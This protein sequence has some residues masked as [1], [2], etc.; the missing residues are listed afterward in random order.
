MIPIEFMCYEKNVETV[1][2]INSTNMNKT[3]NHL[4]SLLNTKKIMTLEIQV[5]AGYRHKNIMGLNQLMEC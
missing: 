3:N 1:M 2:V 4:S 5:L